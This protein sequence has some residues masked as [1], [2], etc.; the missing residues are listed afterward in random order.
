MDVSLG[1]ALLLATALSAAPAPAPTLPAAAAT[2]LAVASGFI[3]PE[4]E[5]TGMVVASAPDPSPMVS[6]LALQSGGIT[7]PR[8]PRAPKTKKGKEPRV[9]ANDSDEGLGA[10]RAQILLRS[11]TVPGWGQATLG[12]KGSSRVFMLAEAGVWGAFAAFRIQEALRTESY[13]RTARLHAGI[14]LRDRD[15]EF[16]RIVGAF[17]SSDEYNLLVVTRDAA[18]LYLRDPEN[19][20]FAGYHAYI[21]QHSL[22]GDMGWRWSDEAAFDRYG[23]QRKFAHRA[24]LRA[25]T[26]LGL[27][28]ANR[29]ISAL[30]AARAAGQAAREAKGAQGWRLEV[31]PGLA[32]PGVYRAALTTRF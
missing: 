15:D 11:L 18:N 29:L 12:R 8:E 2:S 32:E 6:R 19:P 7:A 22:S 25:N 5:P 9:H 20:D 23:G 1:T 4:G 14:D 31:E 26:A 30:H 17:A 24:G 28:V 27:A 16:R 13:L 3:I 21:A 10:A